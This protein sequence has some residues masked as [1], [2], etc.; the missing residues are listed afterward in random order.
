MNLIH[1]LAL[2]HV[3]MLLVEMHLLVRPVEQLGTGRI[4][5]VLSLRVDLLLNVKLGKVL[6]LLRKMLILHRLL[7]LRIQ[8]ALLD[9]SLLVVAV[10]RIGPR[11]WHG[12]RVK[13]ATV[14]QL[15]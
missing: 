7:R 15:A 13:Q 10:G 8:I 6:I 5:I 11:A 1:A 12:A 14:T 3:V 9:N 4:Q 2:K